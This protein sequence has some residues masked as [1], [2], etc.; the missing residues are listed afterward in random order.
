M[1]IIQKQIIELDLPP[2]EDPFY[3][4]DALVRL[5]EEKINKILE[6]VF[7]EFDVGKNINE[8]LNESIPYYNSLVYTSADEWSQPEIGLLGGTVL[9]V[10]D[11]NGVSIRDFRKKEWHINFQG[12]DEEDISLVPRPGEKL[13]AVG[14]DLGNNMFQ[15]E[16]VFSWRK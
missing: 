6:E 3:W 14:K 13:K 5:C 8:S 10:A 16:Q 11:G 2:N 9:T 15:A 12:F 7:D 1:H 4:Q